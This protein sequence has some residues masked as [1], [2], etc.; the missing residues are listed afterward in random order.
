MKTPRGGPRFTTTD[1]NR[2]ALKIVCRRS[3]EKG[4]LNSSNFRD[5][6]DTGKARPMAI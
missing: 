4:D 3:P 1:L 2:L 5:F 6:G